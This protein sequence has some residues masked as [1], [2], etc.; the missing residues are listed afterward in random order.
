VKA[1]AIKPG[2]YFMNGDHACAEGALA[3]GCTFFAG[4]PITPSTEIAERLSRRLPEIGGVFIQMEDEL[5]SIAAVLG[6]SAA[7]SRSMTATSGPGFS[8]MME[9]IGLAAMMEIPCVIVNVQRGSPSTGLPT[10]P[11]Q[12]DMMQARWGSHGDYGLVALSPWSPQEIFNL[13]INSFNIADRFRVPVLLMADEVVGH[14]VE[15]V[16]IPKL[17]QIPAWERKR[18]SRKDKNGFKPFEI[19]DPDLVPA[20]VHAGDGY[21]VH[22]TGLTHDEYGYPDMSAETHQNLVTRLVDKIRVN[23]DE[24]IQI[25]ESFMEG[26]RIVVIAYGSTA[27]SARR[28]VKEARNLGIPAGFLRLIS[29]WPFPEK[30]VRE[31]ALEIDSF[32]VAEMNLGQIVLEV[33]RLVHQPVAGVH[34]AGGAMM[35]PDPILQAIQE[36]ASNGNG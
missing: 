13:T 33:E 7:G 10:L 19:T 8:L 35:S 23:A 36:V 1:A 22:Y 24:I 25:E 32:I 5:G 16:V 17:D 4:Y 21:R 2:P 6:A 28:A 27:R 26:A 34:H 3:A 18:P 12:S 15:R 30:K 11:G 20:M 14:M 31:L 9:N 29:V